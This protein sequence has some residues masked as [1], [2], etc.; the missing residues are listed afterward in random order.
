MKRIITQVGGV[1][2][3]SLAV[4]TAIVSGA[5]TG[6]IAYVMAETTKVE[7]SGAQKAELGAAIGASVSLDASKLDEVSCWTKTNTERSL[8][9]CNAWEDKGA[10]TDEEY[11]SLAKVGSK[12]SRKAF[13]AVELQVGTLPTWDLFT[14]AV[15]STDLQAMHSFQCHR[16]PATP[17]KVWCSNWPI[18]TANK[19]TF[20][21][22]H[23]AGGVI[24]ILGEVE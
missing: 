3:F 17:S 22:D 15:W 20:R 14:Q 4:L 7:L 10:V 6:D 18:K 1:L 12:P 2:A 11:F 5:A 16:D 24:K 8:T 19:A 9:L 13:G 23:E 21:A